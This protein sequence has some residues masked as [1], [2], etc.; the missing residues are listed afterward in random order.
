M[1]SCD[2]YCWMWICSIM[3]CLTTSGSNLIQ[4]IVWNSLFAIIQIFNLIKLFCTLNPLGLKLARY[5]KYNSQ[6]YG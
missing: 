5:K 3:G 4:I 2:K 1:V 6:T